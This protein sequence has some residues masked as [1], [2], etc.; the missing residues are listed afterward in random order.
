MQQIGFDINFQDFSIYLY[1]IILIYNFNFNNCMLTT[2]AY[3]QCETYSVYKGSL[4]NLFT[5]MQC[6]Q[7]CRTAHMPTPAPSVEKKL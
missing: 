3:K 2:S 6:I 5:Y 4:P 7:K 1:I